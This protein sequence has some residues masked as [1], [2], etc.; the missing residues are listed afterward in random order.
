[1]EIAHTGEKSPKQPKQPTKRIPNQK[2]KL[3][4]VKEEIFPSYQLLKLEMMTPGD[5]ELSFFQ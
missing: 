3:H 4:L 5:N 2:T 1:M